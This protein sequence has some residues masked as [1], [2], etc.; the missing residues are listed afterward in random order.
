MRVLVTGGAGFIGSHVITALLAR[1]DSVVCVDSMNDY[2]D[3]T[4][5]R[6]R[7]AAFSHAI[8]HIEID[9]ADREA[10]EQV[11]K[12][13]TFDAVCHLAA[14][15]GVRYSI[16]NP[17]VYADANYVG[18]VNI[19]EYAK[20]HN[21]PHVVFA[22]T[23]SV[24][25]KNEMMPFTEEDR[26]DT[27]ISIYA[28]SKRAGE[29]LAHSYNHLFN[30]NITVL[31]FFTVYGPWGRPDMS[32]ALF[33]KAIIAGEP[34]KV[35]NNGDMERDFTYVSDIVSGILGALGT[36][37][38]FQIYNLGNGKPVPLMDFIHAIEN[39]I[40]KKAVLDLQPM[41]PGDVARTW[42]DTTKAH[43]AFGYA[44]QT[45][46]TEGVDAYVAWYRSYYA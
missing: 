45:N 28:A 15:A 25:G 9:I 37:N 32:L 13:H 24:Y 43:N 42:A 8:E 2:Y 34:I 3:P 6:A 31:R 11:F 17:F 30:M 5:K 35:F 27:P 40:G 22:S 46:V 29:L 19:F 26:V 21:V 23:S 41:Q 33:T 12:T 16:E 1:G 44:P 14:Q 39:S 18:T 38:G 36:P 7:L 4:L 10:V 20:R